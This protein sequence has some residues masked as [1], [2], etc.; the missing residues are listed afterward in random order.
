M[1]YNLLIL[2][3]VFLTLISLIIKYYTKNKRYLNAFFLVPFSIAL[4]L[5]LGLRYDTIGLDTNVYHSTFDGFLY[6]SIAEI[7]SQD[8]TLYMEKGFALMNK[9]FSFISDNYYHFQLFESFL[10][11]ILMM[12]FVKNNAT[13]IILT[14]VLFF[15]S[16]IYLSSFNIFRQCLAVSIAANSYTY[17]KQEK[18]LFTGLLI[19]IAYLMHSSA[20][21]CILITCIYLLRGNKKLLRGYPI[22]LFVLYFTVKPLFV[23]I[24]DVTGKYENYASGEGNLT[25]GFVLVVWCI[26]IFISMRLLLTKNKE[27]HFLALMTITHVF[28]VFSGTQVAYLDRIALYFV[29]FMFL[30]FDAYSNTLKNIRIKY[31]FNTCICICFLLWVF[32]SFQAKTFNP[33]L[34][35]F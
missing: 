25:Y 18:Y 8:K 13:N 20:L 23:Y 11:I 33:Y 16:S 32:I 26:E 24:S 28:V 35:F 2:F 6:Y 4:A 17:L 10:F 27:Y 31:I 29:P 14:S 30:T 19:Y 7:L 15:C 34:L 12:K 21:V 3:V 1:V 9:L 22:V 5:I